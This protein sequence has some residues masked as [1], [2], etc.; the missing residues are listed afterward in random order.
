MCVCVYARVLG[1]KY[2]PSGGVIPMCPGFYVSRV[3]CVPSSREVLCVPGSMCPG[4]YMPQKRVP[5]VLC[6]PGSI[7]PRFYV[8]QLK[9]V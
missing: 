6:V 2:V 3:I 8:S 1:S 9:I 7:C 5:R 4:F